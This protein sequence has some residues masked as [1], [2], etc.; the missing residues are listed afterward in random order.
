MS[1]GC[2]IEFSSAMIRNLALAIV[3][4]AVFLCAADPSIAIQSRAIQKSTSQTAS[5]TPKP[6]ILTNA[7]LGRVIEYSLN[8]EPRLDLTNI[9][10]LVTD[11][12]VTLAGWITE[13]RQRETAKRITREHAGTRKIIDEMQLEQK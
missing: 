7:E 8:Q 4:A 2:A 6:V 13:K 11:D 10:A 3:I 9:R 1:A 12:T 5:A